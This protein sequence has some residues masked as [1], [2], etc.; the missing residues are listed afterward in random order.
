MT[1]NAGFV[2][3][4][5]CAIKID[6]LLFSVCRPHL[7][8]EAGL[9]GRGAPESGE[10]Q[11]DSANADA[12]L[13]AL[14]HMPTLR[15][16]ENWRAEVALRPD[17]LEHR[18]EISAQLD[19]F[20]AGHVLAPLRAQALDHFRKPYSLSVAGRLDDI[21]VV[22]FRERGGAKKVLRDGVSEGA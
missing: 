8:Q 9:I 1:A 19:E 17:S 15:A 21:I 12:R 22:A 20:G 14:A 7:L 2:D 4:G 10:R 5:G 11:D 3:R 16:V 13:R 6:P 18:V